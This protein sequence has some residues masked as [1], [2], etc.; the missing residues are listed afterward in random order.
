MSEIN[1]ILFTVGITSLV[2]FT[3]FL[4]SKVYYK[5]IEKYKELKARTSYMLILYANICSNPIDVAKTNNK[6]PENYRKAGDDLRKLAAEW[7]SLIYIKTWPGIFVMR[8]KKIIILVQHLIGLSNSL[9]LPYNSDN[10]N[11]YRDERDFS[12]QKV[13]EIKKLLNLKS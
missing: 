7:K 4:L 2:N 3:A 9:T 1:K 11:N 10:G 13:N 5:P 12:T 6:L 8:N